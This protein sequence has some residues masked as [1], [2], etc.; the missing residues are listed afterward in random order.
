MHE[1]C[2]RWNLQYQTLERISCLRATEDRCLRRS[3]KHM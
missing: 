2:N 1:E 3:L